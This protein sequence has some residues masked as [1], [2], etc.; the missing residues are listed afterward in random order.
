M[1]TRKRI[2]SNFFADLVAHG[3]LVGQH[4]SWRADGTIEFFDDTPQDVV[5]GVLSVYDAHVPS[6][7]AGPA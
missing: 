4:F 2:G 3:N 5:A 1:V 7:P 6:D